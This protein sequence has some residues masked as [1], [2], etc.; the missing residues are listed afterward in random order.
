MSEQESQPLPNVPF[1]IPELQSIA[2]VIRGYVKYLQSLS[3]PPQER[4]H[5]LE[6]VEKRLRT[7][8]SSGAG[9]QIQMALDAEETA[10][11]LEAMIGFIGL[12]KRLFPQ[13][14]ERDQVIS[15]VN[16]WRLRLI[17]IITEH[18]DE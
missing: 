12:I 2:D 18:I 5:V 16:Y 1:A 11:L 8:L 6:G 14:K 4:I 3:P 17:S 15:T 10:E 9:A 13:N 7:Q